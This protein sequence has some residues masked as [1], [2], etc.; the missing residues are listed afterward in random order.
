MPTVSLEKTCLKISLI[1][2]HRKGRQR[3]HYFNLENTSHQRKKQIQELVQFVGIFNSP[4]RSI[5]VTEVIPKN[6]LARESPY[7]IKFDT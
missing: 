2:I 7:Q 1:G 6:V 5:L 4:R 3:K